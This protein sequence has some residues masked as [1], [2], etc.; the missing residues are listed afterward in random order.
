[1]FGLDSPRLLGSWPAVLAAT[2]PSNKFYLLYILPYVW[3]F[4]SSPHSDHNKKLWW[5]TYY[6][7][8]Y[9]CYLSGIFPSSLFFFFFFL[10]TSLPLAKQWNDNSKDPSQPS[11]LLQMSKREMQDNSDGSHGMKTRTVQRTR[12]W[13]FPPRGRRKGKDGERTLKGPAF[14]SLQN[15]YW[16][17]AVCQGG[18]ELRRPRGRKWLVQGHSAS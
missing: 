4:F 5:I 12:P 6:P 11:S 14:C 15:S 13:N 16:D 1:M 10:A 8:S 18:G 3:K 2:L 17:P 7:L 9:H